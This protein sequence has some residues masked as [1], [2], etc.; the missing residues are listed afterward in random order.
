MALES[1]KKI[2]LLYVY[3]IL[4]DFSD[5]EH[6][7][8]Y[9]DIISKLNIIYGISPNVKSIARNVDT[10][11][12]FGYDVVKIRNNGCYLATR[13]FTN[14]EVMFLVDAVF[15]SKSIAPKDAKEL[16]KKIIKNCSKFEKKKYKHIYKV[17]EISR[18]KNTQLFESIAILDDAI[19][20]GKKVSFRYNEYNTNK[21]FVPR[22]QGYRFTINP[23]FLVNNNGKYYL[24]CNYDKYDDLSNYKIECISD[25][26]I[27][28]E[29]VRQLKT[30]PNYENFRIDKYI[31][32]HIYMTHGNSVDALLKLDSTKEIGDIIDW[33]GEDL[34]IYEKNGTIFAKLT[35]N[36]TALIYWALQYGEHIEI[37]TPEKTREKV[38]E[39]LN[40]MSKKYN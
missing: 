10:L 17:E 29:D 22:M 37:I 32:E 30:L 25:I 19:E 8:T 9:S 13:D 23:Y 5:K 15:S 16:I 31:N 7:L 14:S 28:D 2:V 11:I 6:L 24:V 39:I 34:D 33:Y 38:K 4:K 36:E 27:L 20:K 40:T 35:V 3:E 12:E 21:Q 18:I 26:K 1:D